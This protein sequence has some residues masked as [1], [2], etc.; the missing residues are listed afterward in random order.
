M[1]KTA[2][3]NKM[4]AN[5]KRYNSAWEAINLVTHSVINQNL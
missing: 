1:S 3:Q 5:I 2:K 4:D